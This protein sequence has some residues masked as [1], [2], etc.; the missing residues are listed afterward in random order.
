[1]LRGNGANQYLHLFLSLSLFEL[2]LSETTKAYKLWKSLCI[3][4]GRG[5]VDDENQTQEFVTD[6]MDKSTAN[7]NK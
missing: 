3:S 6:K 5:R 4:S 2:Q 1:M 7:K